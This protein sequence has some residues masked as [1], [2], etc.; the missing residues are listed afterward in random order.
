M[1]TLDIIAYRIKKVLMN[2]GWSQSELARRIGVSQQT[3][4]R[5]VSGIASPTTSN[6]DKLSEITGYP[7]YWFML[8]P[9][10]S[11]LPDSMKLSAKQQE[12][13]RTFNEFPNEEQDSILKELQ[14]E[15]EKMQKMA[16]RWFNTRNKHL[17]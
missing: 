6:M 1:T 16:E 13:L 12:L 8:P 15:K 3:A 5:W 4:Q 11:D 10:E 7:S 17:T 14:M 9:E 2:E